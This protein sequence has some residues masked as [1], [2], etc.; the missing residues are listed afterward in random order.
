MKRVFGF[1]MLA[2]LASVLLGAIAIA[3]G[4][5]MAA[6]LVAGSVAFTAALVFALHLAFG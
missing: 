4:P 2:L 3:V 5:F 6:A 1:A